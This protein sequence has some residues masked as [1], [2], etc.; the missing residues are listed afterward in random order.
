MADLQFHSN[1]RYSTES[2][3]GTA[4]ESR[5]QQDR[6]EG[7][8]VERERESLMLGRIFTGDGRGGGRHR[9]KKSMSR[10]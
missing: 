4:E 1:H 10:K 9:Q 3:R 8:E 7:G 5:P 2:A 6:E